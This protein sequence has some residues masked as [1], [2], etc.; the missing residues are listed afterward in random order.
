MPDSGAYHYAVP[1]LPSPGSPPCCN[2]RFAAHAKSHQ[3]DRDIFAL[4]PTT[5]LTAS[6]SIL[7]QQRK[8]AGCIAYSSCLKT[9]LTR[10]PLPPTPGNTHGP[11]QSGT[12]H[13]PCAVPGAQVP[14]GGRPGSRPV[15]H[16]DG[17]GTPRYDVA[18]RLRSLVARRTRHSRLSARPDAGPGHSSGQRRPR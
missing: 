9:R 17:R 7:P 8:S 14:A 16:D 18:A 12:T 10:L 13:G 1:H 3:L 4:G 5:S 11:C 15:R 2:A 6:T